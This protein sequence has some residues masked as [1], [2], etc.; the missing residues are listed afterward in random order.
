MASK[1]SQKEVENALTEQALLREKFY[2]LKA[3]KIED[4]FYAIIGDDH[5]SLCRVTDLCIKLRDLQTARKEVNKLKK[6]V[7][8]GP[9]IARETFRWWDCLALKWNFGWGRERWAKSKKT[10]VD[11]FQD[12]ETLM[13]GIFEIGMKLFLRRSCLYGTIKNGKIKINQRWGSDSTKSAVTSLKLDNLI[14]YLEPL[15]PEEV[16]SREELGVKLRKWY[17]YLKDTPGN[18][19]NFLKLLMGLNTESLSSAKE[20]FLE[21]TDPNKITEM[22][23]KLLEANTIMEGHLVRV[24]QEQATTGDKLREP[25]WYLGY[26]IKDCQRLLTSLITESTFSGN[27]IN[28][29]SDKLNRICERLFE[30]NTIIGEYVERLKIHET[31]TE[32]ELTELHGYFKHETGKCSKLLKLL[33]D[34]NIQPLLS[35]K[36][37]LSDFFANLTIRDVIMN[38]V[39]TLDLMNKARLGNAL[40]IKFMRT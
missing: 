11:M 29:L 36:T 14:H 3:Q 31:V 19:L 33:K 35:V 20:L 40:G 12:K 2:E 38:V 27:A 4:D 24:M 21:Y 26:E 9:S 37:R 23:K 10:L 15:E 16:T 8:L 6:S 32:E 22:Y 17:G 28:L 5:M 13:Q 34:L 1:C 25:C 7:V 39:D 18:C 30:T